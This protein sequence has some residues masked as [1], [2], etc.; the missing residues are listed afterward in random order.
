MFPN[1]TR[2]VL[3]MPFRS[4]LHTGWLAALLTMCFAG[5]PLSAATIQHT[6]KAVVD[7]YRAPDGATYVAVSLKPVTDL[8]QVSGRDHVLLVDTSASQTG[9]HRDRMLSVV[10]QLLQT[11]RGEDRFLLVAVD[12]QAAMLSDGFQSPFDVA[13]DNAVSRLEQRAP[14]GATDLQA[15]LRTALANLTESRPSTVLYLGDGMSTARLLQS[16]QL[17]AFLRE[18]QTREVPISSVAIGPNT[19]LQLLGILAAHTGGVVHFENSEQPQPA[20]EL[21][22]QVAQSLRASVVFPTQV[23]SQ[24][25]GLQLVPRQAL[26]I[27]SDRETVYLGVGIPAQG[28]QLALIAGEQEFVWQVDRLTETSTNSYLRPAVERAMNDNGLSLAYAGSRLQSV[29]R[30]N[31]ITQVAQLTS[32]GEAAMASRNLKQAEKVALTLRELDPANVQG[33]ALFTA[34]QRLQAEDQLA[35][36]PQQPNAAQP[37]QPAV[38]SDDTQDSLVLDEL[39]QLQLRL[40]ELT[41]RVT[42]DIEAARQLQNQDPEGAMTLLK[43]TLGAVADAD[44]DPERREDLRKRVQT[45]LQDVANRREVIEARQIR[46]AERRAESLAR[47]AVIDEMEIREDE[48]EALIDQVRGLLIQAR[49][50]T[51]FYDDSASSGTTA[52]TKSVQRT[53][54]FEEAE[55]VA[56]VALSKNPGNGIATA[57][58]FNAE[59]AG[60]LAKAEVLRAIRADRFLETLY[61]VERSHIPFP[62]EPPIRWPSAQEWFLLTQKRKKWNSVDLKKYSEAEQ[63]IQDSLGRTEGDQQFLD[64]PLKEALDF[65][66]TLYG[67]TIIIDELALQDEGIDSSETINYSLAKFRCGAC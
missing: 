55:K 21:A 45:V 3:T 57:A 38:T 30:D 67:I 10:R 47:K 8:P 25:E 34:V 62:D 33:K 4:T 16:S 27:R 37:P 2:G 24:P 56:R 20:S 39:Q 28:G 19:D 60:Q 18:F 5:Y 63:K 40:Q 59:A 1:T 14:L 26:P 61:Q 11:M 53:D 66:A 35:Q 29:A 12:S 6:S 23:A 15:G 50:L 51:A 43:R 44:I 42:R 9:A 13:A 54:P 32:L 58:V 65:L 36:A 49:Q 52:F 41:S 22:A 17:G 48:L 46:A 31:F 7:G 64:I